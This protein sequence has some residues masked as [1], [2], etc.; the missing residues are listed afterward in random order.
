MARG[1]VQVRTARRRKQWTDLP[2]VAQDQTGNAT[3]ILGSLAFAG[4]GNTVLRLIGQLVI[5]PTSAPVALDEIIM[6]YAVGVV[7]SDAV[8]AAATPDPN[9]EAEYPWLFWASIPFRF[10]DSGVDPSHAGGSYRRAFDIKSQR[11]ISAGQSL[12]HVVQYANLNGNPPMTTV[13]G[14]VRVLLALP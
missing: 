6:C 5:V 7:S 2:G 14:N 3:A 9:A 1:H 11:K 8:A 10:N 13:I 12:V 4:G